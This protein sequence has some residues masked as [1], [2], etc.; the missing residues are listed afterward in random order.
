M[1]GPALR[2]TGSV[3]YLAQGRL[4]SRQRITYSVGSTGSR[5]IIARRPDGT[6]SPDT[7]FGGSMDAPDGQLSPDGQWLVLR[8]GTEG[9]RFRSIAS[10]RPGV[11]A[12]TSSIVIGGGYNAVQPALSPD[13]QLAGL[14]LG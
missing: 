7:L 3:P 14:Y 8:V 12:D 13:G 2:A 6:G 1:D 5:S 9:G 4:R 11:D 10:V